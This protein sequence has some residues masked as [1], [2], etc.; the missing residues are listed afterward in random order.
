MLF[1][2]LALPLMVVVT[3]ASGKTISGA[4]VDWDVSAGS[5]STNPASSLSD[6]KG[7]AQTLWTLGTV[8]SRPAQVTA[9]VSG[10]APVTFTAT[11]LAGPAVSVIATPE[12]AFL[13][14]GDSVR[15]SGRAR[16]VR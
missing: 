11:V 16:P 1:R 15:V 9:Q 6:S 14:V 8:A 13:G 3:D 7:V 12:L 5:G 10:V 2:S 4:R